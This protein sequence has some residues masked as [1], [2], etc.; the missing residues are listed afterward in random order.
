[1]KKLLALGLAILAAGAAQAGITHT[2][3][4]PLDNTSYWQLQKV[5]GSYWN[6]IYSVVTTAATVQFSH[7]YSGATTYP[8]LGALVWTAPA[9]EAI[10]KISFNYQNNLDPAAWAQ[11]VFKLDPSTNLA[12]DSAILWTAP[13]S[14]SLAS[15]TL[16]YTLGDNVQRIGL[17]FKAIGTDYPGWMAYFQSA[18]I[19]TEVI[20][21][22]ASLGLLALG[23]LV[24]GRRRR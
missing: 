16:A 6:V 19:T 9:G 22:P 20:P 14:G 15:Q 3:T 1:M 24:L 7:T 10:T 4:D 2:Y 23:A 13:A 17:G 11:E 12:A 8:N 5:D 18:S 21:E